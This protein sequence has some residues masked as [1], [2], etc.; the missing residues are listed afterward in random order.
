MLLLHLVFTL[1][2]CSDWGVREGALGGGAVIG[3]DVSVRR[4]PA[5]LTGGSVRDRSGGVVSAAHRFSLSRWLM[6]SFIL[7]TSLLYSSGLLSMTLMRR[8]M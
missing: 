7:V 8:V 3:G 6:M 5:A 2:C 4:G 1:C